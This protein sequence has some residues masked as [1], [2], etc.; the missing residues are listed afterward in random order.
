MQCRDCV[1]GS[2][3]MTRNFC[4]YCF[5]HTIEACFSLRVTRARQ[6]AAL[7]PH[8]PL[9][10]LALDC[11]SLS[12][13]GFGG[14][15]GQAATGHAGLLAVVA[16]QQA[17]RLHALQRLRPRLQA[18]VLGGRHRL[19][20]LCMHAP[21]RSPGST[22]TYAQCTVTM[23]CLRGVRAKHMRVSASSKG[24]PIEIRSCREQSASLAVL[25]DEAR[26]QPLLEPQG[27]KLY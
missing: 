2:C 5:A 15:V 9:E 11:T 18:P 4:P 26:A 12:V 20:V 7:Q 8:R 13:I 3:H 16:G 23:R 22:T 21:Q 25:P 10:L 27:S 24:L 6:H 1:A 19:A 17:G 14:R